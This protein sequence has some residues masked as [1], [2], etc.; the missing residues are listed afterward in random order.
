[1]GADIPMKMMF[2]NTQSVHLTVYRGNM[3]DNWR[4]SGQ[5]EY[6][7]NVEWFASLLIILYGFIFESNQVGKLSF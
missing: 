6:A 5:P 1:M 3:L 7:K 4:Q 2:E